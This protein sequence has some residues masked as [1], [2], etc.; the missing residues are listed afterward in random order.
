MHKWTGRMDDYNIY[1][2]CSLVSQMVLQNVEK[3][4]VRLTAKKDNV[5]GVTLP[6]FQISEEGSDSKQ[7]LWNQ[8]L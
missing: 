4:Q 1:F 6:I 2:D 5:A 7:W 3:A 8:T